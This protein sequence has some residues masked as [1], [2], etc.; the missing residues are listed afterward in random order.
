MEIGEKIKR[1]RKK[2]KLSLRDLAE[3][4]GLTASFLSQI[5]RDQASPSIDSLR[6]ISRA[7]DVPV[8]YFLLERDGPSPV[9][10]RDQRRH[11]TLP[12]SNITYQLLTPNVNR[13]MGMILATLDPE[14]GEVPLV[15]YRHTEECIFVLEGEL[16]ITLGNELHHLEAG[17]AVYFDGPMLQRMQACGDTQVKY[18]SVITPPIF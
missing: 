4:V 14:D 9:V 1:R 2:M 12:D 13:K 17:D 5:E 11:L 18:I 6:K 10:R 16:E 15:H 3:K 8:F 7:L